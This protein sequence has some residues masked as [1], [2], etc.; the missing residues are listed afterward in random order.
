MRST[1]H[2]HAKAPP[3]LISSGR[4]DCGSLPGQA[5]KPGR[6]RSRPLLGLLPLALSLVVGCAADPPAATL[7]I[8]IGLLADSQI[9]SLNGTPDCLYRSR[10]MDKKVEPAIRPPALEYLAA[11]MLEIAL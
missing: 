9:T 11:E 8:R 1:K 3:A 7:P 6:A 5:H 2:S 4:I 10:T